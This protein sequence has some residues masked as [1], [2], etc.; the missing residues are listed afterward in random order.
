LEDDRG[1]LKTA[2]GRKT[3]ATMTK[4][5]YKVVDLF[6]NEE[7]KL[8]S[9]DLNKRPNLFTDHDA[10]V[11]KFE[12]KKTTDDCY[13]PPEVFDIIVQHVR[14]KC[15]IEGRHIIRPF[16]PGGDFEAIDYPP[17]CVVID[18]P[19][20]SIIS[21][22]SRF[23]IARQVPF[24][25]F[26]PHLTLFSAGL[27]CTHIVC[28]GD[29]TYENGATVK[30]SFLSNLFGDAKIIGD[31]ELLDKFKRYNAGKKVNLPKYV[32]PD[33]VITVSQVAYIIERGVSIQINKEHA[34]HCRALDAQ[35]VHGKT[36]FGSG[37]L[38]SEKAAAEK[39]AAE[40]AAAEKD[41][42]IVWELSEKEKAIIQ[43]LG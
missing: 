31:A 43:S 25:L 37:F 26:A 4:R 28:G 19:P 17:D 3:T 22:I 12:V 35:K 15:N 34:N 8:I 23:Y 14:E 39:A 38:L 36:I 33:E 10:F 40:K 7:L 20:F 41:D 21:K 11:E 1:E 29:I 6:G 2:F 27:D 18:N 5:T 24:F 13:T 9:S 32:Y 42:V 30:T 16:Y